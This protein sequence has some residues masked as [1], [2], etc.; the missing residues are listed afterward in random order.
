MPRKK[1]PC[2]KA[3]PSRKK[4]ENCIH[5]VSGDN[6]I[7]E[8]CKKSDAMQNCQ[9]TIST[10][11]SV[12]KHAKNDRP[13]SRSTD[14]ARRAEPSHDAVEKDA[15]EQAQGGVQKR[16]KESSSVPERTPQK[17]RRVNGLRDVI[18]GDTV[19]APD[20]E[21]MKIRGNGFQEEG[22]DRENN[23]DGWNEYDTD[24]LT[25]NFDDVNR[26]QPPPMREVIFTARKNIQ[27]PDGS[28]RQ[29]EPDERYRLTGPLFKCC[30]N[31]HRWSCEERDMEEL[32]FQVVS[33]KNMKEMRSNGDDL[34][35]QSDD[36]VVNVRHDFTVERGDNVARPIDVVL[37]KDNL[38]IDTLVKLPKFRFLGTFCFIDRPKTIK[39][40]GQ[41]WCDTM[42]LC[43]Q[44]REYITGRFHESDEFPNV[45]SKTKWIAQNNA[46]DIWRKD[47]KKEWDAK[48]SRQCYWPAH[49]WILLCDDR[50]LEIQAR[51]LW[52]MLPM[53]MRGW[54]HESIIRRKGWIFCPG[55]K[56]KPS[57]KRMKTSRQS[58]YGQ[59]I[60]A[61]MPV[62]ADSD[63]RTDLYGD[64]SLNRIVP[65]KPYTVCNS[66]DG[67]EDMVTGIWMMGQPILNVDPYFACDFIDGHQDM[68]MAV[69]T[70]QSILDVDMLCHKNT[71]PGS[72]RSMGY[73]KGFDVEK[74]C[75][76]SNPSGMM[77]TPN[78]FLSTGVC[79]DVC[80]GDEDDPY[81]SCSYE[82]PVPMFVDRSTEY[83]E[84]L[85]C[86]DLNVAPSLMHFFDNHHSICDVKCP[87]GCTSFLFKCGSIDFETI[88]F[89]YMSPYIDRRAT[90]QPITRKQNGLV[91]A[92]ND[93]LSYNGSWI[94]QAKSSSIDINQSIS[95]VF[96]MTRRGPMVATC[97]NHD[98]GSK[99]RYLHP[100]MNPATGPLPS[101]SSSQL[102]HTVMVPR[103]VKCMRA[104]TYNTTFE[105]VECNGN[106]KG[107][108]SM[109]VRN[110]GNLTL[111]S[112]V[113][114]TNLL[115]S[116]RYRPD[117]IILLQKLVK[118]GVIPQ[119]FA[120]ETILAAKALFEQ[121]VGGARED[122]RTVYEEFSSPVEEALEGA[123]SISFVDSILLERILSKC[124]SCRDLRRKCKM[125]IHSFLK[126]LF[127]QELKYTPFWCMFTLLQVS[128]KRIVSYRRRNLYPGGHHLLFGFI[129]VTH[130]ELNPFQ[131]L[132]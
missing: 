116:V 52:S 51:F 120:S 99:Q 101:R 62:L 35:L 54:W 102:A 27:E 48:N 76:G 30:E 117:I 115:L 95:R 59:F 83:L 4:C 79:A 119:S 129:R 18:M 128:V 34:S 88:I 44:C 94:P 64:R 85:K 33:E 114:D 26:E 65:E 82:S 32:D 108:D 90:R 84:C 109:D 55:G 22:D 24:T 111:T 91:G 2:K 78:N 37:H 20:T 121:K 71:G 122:I 12:A 92:R 7:C 126:S 40:G 63:N 80:I 39:S 72:Q 74:Y 66:I 123:T 41:P 96:L 81:F 67:H 3:K 36:A 6:D 124:F 68:V 31:C 15:V 61:S 17:S 1:A 100:P 10:G 87:F 103:V 106:Y 118:N 5:F 93:F 77:Y 19:D 70:E 56:L 42:D 50:V 43:R 9:S 131:F 21:A 75:R 86:R 130:M 112:P 28:Y 49:V 11:I 29:F 8:P 53:V 110:G 104:H 58:K 107:I 132:K 73:C 105:V 89:R 25:I 97:E 47:N 16:K 127:L 125:F 57:R 113:H 14:V 13:E 23:C 46:Y 38:E 45:P 60:E 69:C 98:E